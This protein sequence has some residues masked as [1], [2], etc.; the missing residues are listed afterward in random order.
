MAEMT[1]KGVIQSG[2]CI[3]CGACRAADSSIRL[4]LSEKR[5]IFEPTS[6]GDADAATVCPSVKV[7]YDKLLELIF[8]RDRVIS[9]W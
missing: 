1:L 2:M 8:E 6:A 7:D 3:A 5:Q 4:E 9:W